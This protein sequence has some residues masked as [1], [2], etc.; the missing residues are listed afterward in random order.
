MSRD[1]EA[2]MWDPGQYLRYADERARPFFDLLSRVRATD[3]GYV[4]DLGCGPGNLTAALADRWPGAEVVGVDS[5]AEMVSAA[6][7]QASERQPG[8]PAEHLEWL[9]VDVGPFGLPGGHEVV[10][11][12]L[13]L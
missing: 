1:L 5:S 4:A 8:H 2:G 6:R 12:V 3:P 11:L 10:D 13:R 9:D 7:A